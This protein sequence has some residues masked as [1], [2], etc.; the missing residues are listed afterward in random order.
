MKINL[1]LCSNDYLKLKQSI[2]KIISNSISDKNEVFGW[3]NSEYNQLD[4]NN[5]IQQINTPIHLKMLQKCGK[6][7]DIATGG[8]GCMVLNGILLCANSEKIQ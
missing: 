1:S 6:I 8:S 7:T 5:G 3:G 2:L 4:L